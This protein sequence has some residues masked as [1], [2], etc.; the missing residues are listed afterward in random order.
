M[1][2][3]IAD[4]CEQ[5][6]ADGVSV[7]ADKLLRKRFADVL[8]DEMPAE[9]LYQV[10]KQFYPDRF[11]YATDRK[12]DIYPLNQP[13]LSKEQQLRQYLQNHG[14]CVST[15]QIA[16]NLGWPRYMLQQAAASIAEV[17][18]DRGVV[19][20]INL[21]IGKKI[22]GPHVT[23]YIHSQLR[24]YGAMYVDQ[25]MD[26]YDQIVAAIDDDLWQQLV[27][28]QIFS[29]KTL[30]SFVREIMPDIVVRENLISFKK[31]PVTLAQ[32]NSQ[33]TVEHSS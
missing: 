22:I 11:Q 23:S 14:Q 32:F 5:Q 2:D 28:A 4:F 31:K 17:V 7:L 26:Y 21:K 33:E 18:L 27:T 9:E 19:Y 1:F 30:L 25:V 16:A 15:Q 3:L 13:L 29:R 24:S 20:T 6:F 12:T 8:P 10:F